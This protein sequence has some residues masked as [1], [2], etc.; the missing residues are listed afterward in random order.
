M[1]RMKEILL[2]HY[3]D[4]IFHELEFIVNYETTDSFESHRSTSGLDLG[5]IHIYWYKFKSTIIW[6]KDECF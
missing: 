4:I 3:S 2:I 5:I 1:R 6:E